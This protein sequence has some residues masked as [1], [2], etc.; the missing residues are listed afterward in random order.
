MGDTVP[1]ATGRGRGDDGELPPCKSL[2]PVLAEP[3]ARREKPPI[4]P[5]GSSSRPTEWCRNTSSSTSGVLGQLERPP[6]RVTVPPG[7]LSSGSSRAFSEFLCPISSSAHLT[8][9]PLDSGLGGSRSLVRNV[10]PPFRD[11]PGWQ[12]AWFFLARSGSHSRVP[13]APPCGPP[14][15]IETESEPARLTVDRPIADRYPGQ[16]AGL[17]FC[18]GTPRTVVSRRRYVESLPCS[19]SWVRVALAGG[20]RCPRGQEPWVSTPCA[21]PRRS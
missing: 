2:R 19:S 21:G 15:G 9:A 18:R 13:W 17:L 12:L 14:P 4:P 16:S 8:L 20:N 6:T 5:A 7:F 10:R 1:W 3:P 11:D